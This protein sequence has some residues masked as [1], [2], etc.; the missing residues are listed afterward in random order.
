MQIIRVFVLESYGIG[1]R[2]AHITY[3]RLRLFMTLPA[4]QQTMQLIR[5]YSKIR[6]MVAGTV[7]GLPIRVT[8]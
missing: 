1:I 8:C 3:K 6:E 4:T 5:Q 7:F 2:L